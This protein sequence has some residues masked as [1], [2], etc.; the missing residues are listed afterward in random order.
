LNRCR[1]STGFALHKLQELVEKIRRAYDTYEFHAIY[2]ALYNYCTLDLSAFYL[3]ILKDRLYTSA[4]NSLGR[5]SAQTVMHT[6]LGTLVR[7]M[8]PVLSFTGEEI[9]QY[10]P[11]REENAASI[12]LLS[13]PDVKEEWKDDNLAERWE[14]L[15]A[16]R[17]E[18]TKALEKARAEKKIGHPLD[19]AVT[20]VSNGDLY[21]KLIQFSDDLRSVF[22]VSSAA[23]VKGEK[24][25][26]AYESAE[27]ENLSILV[28]PAKGDKCER[29]WIHKP[30][31]GQSADHPAIC[32]RCLGVLEELK[33]GC[34]ETESFC[35]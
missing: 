35:R 6:A 25:A 21:Q 29:C 16:V 32:D 13:L 7:L 9:W 3:D 18:V 4:S 22:I 27:I 23:L 12:H 28:E 15:I 24:P 30:S 17:G 2:H 11:G 5:R 34:S 20:I 31:V 1:I 8:A 14:R 33:L 26:E 19:A 10:M